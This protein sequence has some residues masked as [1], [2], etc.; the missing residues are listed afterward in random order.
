MK[1]ADCG[2]EIRDTAKVCGYCGYKINISPESCPN[3]GKE[4]REG[5]KVCGYCGYQFA[6]AAQKRNPVSRE[7]KQEPEPA[8]QPIPASRAEAEPVLSTPTETEP[9]QAPERPTTPPK[10]PKA[11]SKSAPLPEKKVEAAPTPALDVSEKKAKEK[12]TSGQR[13]PTWVWIV[14]GLA[15]IIGIALLLLFTT[16]RLPVP[17][18]E[19]FPD[20]RVVAQEGFNNN[21]GPGFRSQNISIENG[22][23]R[24]EGSGVQYDNYILFVGP[25]SV[26]NGILALFKIEPEA[27]NTQWWLIDL[28]TYYGADDVASVGFSEWYHPYVNIAGEGSDTNFAGMRTPPKEGV[29]YYVLYAITDRD[30]ISVRIWEQDNP[31]RLSEHTWRLGPELAGRSWKAGFFAHVGDLYLDSVQILSLSK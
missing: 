24:I 28:Y 17:V 20:A 18:T 3:C 21:S 15:G 2:K 22:I 8:P 7:T 11:L 31:T 13:F 5:A 26:S 25:F 12:Q 27:D 29:W 1:C 30:E 23:A 19:L 9:L 6:A 14:M 10:N 16:N 4:V